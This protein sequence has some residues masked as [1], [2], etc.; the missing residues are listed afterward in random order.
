MRGM[1]WRYAAAIVFLIV[2]GCGTT[3]WSDT[4]RTATEQMLLS[5][6]IDRA[7]TQLDFRTLAGK[8]VFFDDQYLKGVVDQNYIVS[9]LRQHLLASGAILKEKRED[10]TYVVEARAGA[11]GTDRHDLL[12]GVPSVT[13]PSFVAIPGAPS[14]IPEIPLV[15]E[16]EQL[17]VAKVAVFAYNRITGRP[18]WQ[19]GVKPVRST[20]ED[21]WV[22]GAGPFQQGTIYDRTQFAGSSLDLPLIGSDRRSGMRNAPVAVTAEMTFPEPIEQR[23]SKALAN[24]PGGSTRQAVVRLPATADENKTDA[25]AGPE[26]AE[27]REPRRLKP[28][29]LQNM[30]SASDR[31]Q[32]RSDVERKP[33]HGDSKK[34]SGGGL[35]DFLK[36]LFGGE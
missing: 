12:F 32:R 27:L 13:V 10:A 5:D 8:D 22:F 26:N 21:T 33:A 14:S 20:A 11:V 2:G 17:A 4:P 18:V 25:E 19:S 36:P 3:R 23:D 34:K 1:N 30:R 7:V 6:A 24:A 16:T 35:F 29:R 9:T 28:P 15:K 31:R